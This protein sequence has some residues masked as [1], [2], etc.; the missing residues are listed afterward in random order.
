MTHYIYLLIIPY[1]LRAKLTLHIEHKDKDEEDDTRELEVN[2]DASM[3]QRELPPALYNAP[4][5]TGTSLQMHIHC[6]SIHSLGLSLTD[7]DGV[8]V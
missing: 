8:I 1:S 6:L 2:L 5:R 4:P 7:D 3:P